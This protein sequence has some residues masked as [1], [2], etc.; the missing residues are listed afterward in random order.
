M[1]IFAFVIGVRWTENTLSIQNIY[2]LY[3]LY[4]VFI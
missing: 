4:W 3:A 1:F 2:I